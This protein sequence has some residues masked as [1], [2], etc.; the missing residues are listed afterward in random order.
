MLDR[1]HGAGV[2]SH[3]IPYKAERRL[4]HFGVGP[5]YREAE[6]Q[7]CTIGRSWSLTP[8]VHDRLEEKVYSS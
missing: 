8:P 1:K 5:S 2:W 6:P 3:N 4:C 7:E